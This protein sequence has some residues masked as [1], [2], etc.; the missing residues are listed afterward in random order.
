MFIKSHYVTTESEAR[1]FV[2]NFFRYINPAILAKISVYFTTIVKQ[3]GNSLENVI[4]RVP[5]NED[6]KKM[7]NVTLR[8]FLPRDARSASAVLPS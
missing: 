6:A 1:I 7:K 5:F 8:A 2:E 3:S 4:V